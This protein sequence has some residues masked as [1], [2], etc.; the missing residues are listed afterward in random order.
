MIGNGVYAPGHHPYEYL[1]QQEQPN[2]RPNG[3]TLRISPSKAQQNEI[4]KI[5]YDIPPGL[6]FPRNS[7]FMGRESELSTIDKSFEKCF[8]ESPSSDSPV[9]CALT[10]TGGMGKTQ[11]AL[12]FAYRYREM[13]RLTSIFWV[14][15]ATEETIRASWVKIMQQIVQ[16]Q[17]RVSWPR[18][19]PD[20]KAVSIAVG[21]PGLVDS[22]GN[23]NVSGD[24]VGIIQSALFNWLKLPGNRKW[25]LIFDNADNLEDF[26]INEY[27]PNHGGGGILVTSRRQNFSFCA[28][29][30]LLDG[31]D[32]DNSV[33]LLFRLA[34]IRNP[35]EEEK[36]SAITIVR[37][38]GF[39]PLAITHAGCFIH[40]TNIHVQQFL[41]YYEEAF[42]KAQSAVPRIG[43]WYRSDTALTTWEISFSEIEKQDKE[44]AWILL[45]CSYLSPNE[46]SERLWQGNKS[47]S[48]SLFKYANKFDLLASYSL[49]SRTR[50]GTFSIHPVVHSWARE[51]ITGIDRTRLVESAIDLIGEEL[52]RDEYN[53]Q[54]KKW[55]GLEVRKIVVHGGVLGKHLESVFDEKFEHRLMDNT[56]KRQ[57]I[58]STIFAMA[59]IYKIQG[60]YTEA[61]QWLRRALA[62]MKKCLGENHVLTIMATQ[63]MAL[64]YQEQGKNTMEVLHLLEGI[65]NSENP[66]D[67]L[68][69][70]TIAH[71]FGFLMYK[72]GWQPAEAIN[73]MVRVLFRRLNVLGENHADTL[74]SMHD[75]ARIFTTQ[76]NY[77]KAVQALLKVLAGRK[78][79]GEHHPSTLVTVYDLALVYKEQGKYTEAMQLLEKVLDGRKKVLGEDH[80]DT[81]ITIHSIASV[82]SDQGKYAEAIQCL[83]KALALETIL[84]ENHPLILNTVLAVAQAYMNQDKYTEASQPIRRLLALPHELWSEIETGI[85]V[86]M[87]GRLLTHEEGRLADEKRQLADRQAELG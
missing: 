10:G 78:I 66:S 16:A 6:P 9:I 63:N 86:P 60:K 4:R 71:N 13:R 14:S 83:Q 3:G 72:N 87:V 12:E 73:L 18:S 25:L 38:L 17:A 70:L 34:Q 29:M 47:D 44:A 5:N 19:N 69:A 56:D 74:A 48:E 64:I 79:L 46:I 35:T 50:G 61:I 54:S 22:N 37:K 51:R 27:F 49:I 11:I 67:E 39:M 26:A 24:G 75:L 85:F 7:S 32:I 21:I 1:R 40:Q 58:F 68:A 84:G 30:V 55:N 53:I 82:Y 42:K 43:W 23:I 52:R 33:A 65:F 45:V 77:T 2:S 8:S 57:R 31:L 76:G 20:Y 62:G 41:K 28:E 80:P 15:A 36:S 81:F 59:Q